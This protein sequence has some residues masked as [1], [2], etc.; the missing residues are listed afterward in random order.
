MEF[1]AKVVPDAIPDLPDLG[2]AF[3][4]LPD[5]VPVEVRGTLMP[6]G[7]VSS[8]FLVTRMQAKGVPLPRRIFEEVL[9]ALGRRDLQG[10]PPE[11]IQI[12]VPDGVRGA[13]VQDSRL[14]LIRR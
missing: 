6:F 4:V 13:Y 12:P 7:D 1:H 14:V 5:T 2:P 11:G 3:T 10:L 9:G 8:V